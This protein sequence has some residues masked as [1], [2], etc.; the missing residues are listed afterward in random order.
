[1]RYRGKEAIGLAVSMVKDGDVLKLGEDLKRSMQDIKAELPLGVEFAQVSDQ[2]HV[3]KESVAEFMTAL[4]EAV[5]IVLLVSF[6]ALRLRAGLVVAVTIPFV[7]AATF[8]LML[9]FKI[10]LHRISTGALIIALGLLVDDAMIAIEMMARK[11]EEGY[12]RFAAATFAFQSTVD[13]DAHRHPDHRRRLPADRHGEIRHRRIHLRHFRRGRHRAA[14][15]LGGRGDHHAV[16]RLQHSQGAQRRRRQ[17]RRCTTRR[18]TSASAVWSTG[19]S[20]TANS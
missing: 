17:S 1:M 7:L 5:A 3:V 15:V 11:L 18:S 16:S 9:Y 4:G 8:L 6:V 2:P 12:D 19:A 13:A 20:S 10:D 14:D